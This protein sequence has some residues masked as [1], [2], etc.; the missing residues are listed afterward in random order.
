MNEYQ[1]SE[2]FGGID[3]DLSKTITFTTRKIRGAFNILLK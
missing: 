2:I 3:S 1:S